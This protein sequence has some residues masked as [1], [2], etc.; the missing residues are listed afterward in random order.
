MATAVITLVVGTVVV[1]NVVDD[2]EPV[3]FALRLVVSMVEVSAVVSE[4]VVKPS[5]RKFTIRLK[6]T[7]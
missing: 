3:I 4:V 6:P 1:I 2:V 7:H 5:F